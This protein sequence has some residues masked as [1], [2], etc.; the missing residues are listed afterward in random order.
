MKTKKTMKSIAAAALALTLVAAPAV[1]EISPLFSGTSV[2]IVADAATLTKDITEKADLPSFAAGNTYNLKLTADLTS[3]EKTDITIPKGSIVNLDLNGHAI[4]GATNGIVNNG[5]FTIKN[6]GADAGATITAPAS[7]SAI[8]NNVGGTVTIEKGKVIGL[9]SLPAID[10]K[11]TLNIKGGTVNGADATSIAIQN[12]FADKAAVGSNADAKLTIS[13]GTFT[14]A[15]VLVNN[16]CGADA[17]ISGGTFTGIASGDIAIK[18]KDNITISGGTFTNA[19]ATKAIIVSLSNS[20]D[21]ACAAGTA[22]ITGGTF[23]ATSSVPVIAETATLASGDALGVITISSGTFTTPVIVSGQFTPDGGSAADIPTDNLKITGKGVKVEVADDTTD[24]TKIDKLQKYIASDATVTLVNSG[25]HST[26]IGDVCKE[27]KAKDES[28]FVSDDEKG[29]YFVCEHCDGKYTV[30][31][32]KQKPGVATH[33]LSAVTDAAGNEKVDWKYDADGVPTKETTITYKCDDCD[34]TVAL[35]ATAINATPQSPA[36]GKVKT[37]YTASFVYANL[38]INKT[39]VA[40]PKSTE[41]DA[42][43]ATTRALVNDA[44]NIINTEV[45]GA[46]KFD[47]IYQ[48]ISDT[49]NTEKITE[50]FQTWL[51]AQNTT[52]GDP[53]TFGDNVTVSLTDVKFTK[54]T[55]LEDGKITGKM[56]LTAKADPTV[57]TT[58]DLDAVWKSALGS[59]T[60][61]DVA[62]VV[63]TY[64]K[65]KEDSYIKETNADGIKGDNTSTPKTGI[66]K[67]LEDGNVTG[68]DITVEKTET[69]ATETAEGKIVV[70]VVLK[71]SSNMVYDD[72]PVIREVVL[73]KLAL[74]DATKVADAKPVVNGYLEG[75][76]VT[77]KTTAADVEAKI[78]A[79]VPEGAEVKVTITPA[80]DGKTAAVSAEITSGEAK[81]T[82]EAK[83][84]PIEAAA[85]AEDTDKT[86]AAQAASAVNGYLEAVTIGKDT[87]A[88]DVEAKLKTLVP[89]GTDVKVTLTPAADGKTATVSAVITSGTATENVAAKTKPVETTETETVIPGDMDGDG[90]VTTRDYVQLKRELRKLGL[91]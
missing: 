74:S 19:A 42:D 13:G 36:D 17:T 28:V 70:K 29:H 21:G 38:S 67:A 5:T 86:K 15:G 82:I 56:T 49:D 58:Y 90:K 33:N 30:V 24:A 43:K 54:A 55:T 65:G 84:K 16:L 81:E 72:K 10:N 89:E 69:A 32:G 34:Y 41:E 27:H 51:S 50:R 52:S 6:S 9:A 88:A 22:T 25:D 4:L 7:K 48:Q 12:G 59:A 23:T 87:T 60:V 91:L 3:G 85:A 68:W 31:G 47:N 35:T 75:L 62:A 45:T 77:D 80:E 83:T 40:C 20:N 57:S 26:V 2:G 61:D 63:D 37:L 46:N 66:Y 11:G 18:N 53:V 39:G 44:K 78:K 1:Q 79:L 8:T 73:P 76:T 14:T 64:L 71:D